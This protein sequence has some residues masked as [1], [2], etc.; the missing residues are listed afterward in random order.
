[1]GRLYP[2]VDHVLPFGS[3]TEAPSGSCDVSVDGG[4]PVPLGVEFHLQ[5]HHRGYGDQLGQCWS[6]QDAVVER[7]TIDHQKPHLDLFGCSFFIECD[8]ELDVSPWLGG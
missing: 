4:D 5:V 8:K 6:P 7:W 3:R 2:S 1:M